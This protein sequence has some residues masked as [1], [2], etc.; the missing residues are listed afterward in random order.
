MPNRLDRATSPYLLQHRDNPVHWQEWGDAAFVEARERNVP[1]LL[2]VGYAAC[3]WC[4]VMAHESFEDEAVAAALNDRFVSVKVDR[5]ERPDI[6]AVYMSAVTATTGHGGWPMTVFLTP[7]GEPFF[8]G[9][10]FPRDHFLHVL[11]ALD[12]AWRTREDE[13]R[14]SGAHIATSLAEALRPPTP[15]AVE[16]GALSSAVGL[17]A[18]QFDRVAGGFGGA[19]KFP[20]SMV[21]EFLLRHHA[22]TG[23]RDA[24][25][26]ASRTL[27][28]MARS[29]LYD[30]LAGGFARYAVDAGWVVP[31]FEK[32]LYD[33]ALLLRAYTSWWKVSRD[34]LAERIVRETADFVVR[35]L[36]TETGGFASSLDA[37][38]AGVEGLTYAWTPEQLC[39]VLG[40]DDGPVAAELLGV[41]R[42][43]TFEHGASTLQLPSEPVDRGWFDD[44][45]ARLLAARAE[46][47]QPGRD[48][49]VVTSW[50]GL[51]VAALAGA[52][53]AFG[54]R[55]WVAAATRCAEHVLDVH[56]VDGQ[57]RRASRGGMVG[58]A[59]AVA[60]DHG[61]L[62]DGLLVLHQVSGDQRWLEAARR[63]LDT[64]RDF[65]ADDGGFHDTAS[66][67]EPLYLRPRSAADNAEPAGQ[68]ALAGALVTLGAVTGDSAALAAGATS[69]AAGMGLAVREPRFGGWSLAVAESLVAGPL[70]VAVVGSGRDADALEAVA[71]RSPSPGLVVVRGEP[72]APGVPLLADRPLVGGR[73]A[74]YVCRGMVCEL[75]TT[76]PDVLA[77]QLRAGAAEGPGG[78][79][80]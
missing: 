36:G 52:G 46:R 26:M 48:D 55:D 80:D 66:D 13:V 20:P 58:T 79:V 40:D 54:R 62:A 71:R 65:A 34:P 15:Y 60:D 77:A 18:R 69:T 63:V 64:A 7:E 28:A 30:Q 2:S 43:G 24:L 37:D 31:H 8:C 17:L 44:V 75:P 25:T 51:T 21:L 10:Y 19:P 1:V 12:E 38:A 14:A 70:Q 9:T 27:E 56:V 4:H 67:A 49:K 50:N 61:N 57:L 3:H 78:V 42:E 59:R 45:R 16:P 72:D 35:E 53:A 32:M 74:A 6:D 33:N 22:R 68:S 73:A 41:T 76:D 23:D 29:G 11:A 47:P 5:E 39:E